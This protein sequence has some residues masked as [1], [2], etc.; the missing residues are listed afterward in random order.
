MQDFKPED[1]YYID[2]PISRYRAY[3]FEITA[4][5]LAR[6]G[7]LYLSK[8]RRDNKQV[9]PA[10]W[11]EKNESANEI[12]RWHDADAGGYENLWWLEYKGSHLFGNG[13]PAGAYTASGAGVHVVMV[14]PSLRGFRRHQLVAVRHDASE[15]GSGI[16]WTAVGAALDGVPFQHSS[17]LEQVLNSREIAN[18]RNLHQ[19]FI[20]LTSI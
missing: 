15:L 14:I 12:I 19:Q 2:G 17:A 20:A 16:C 13:L 11:V 8:G 9:V 5:D 7:L 18:T 1:V 3:H 4:R 6:F 10:A